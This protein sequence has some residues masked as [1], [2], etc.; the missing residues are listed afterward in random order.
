[1]AHKYSH[2]LNQN[3]E[4]NNNTTTDDVDFDDVDAIFE[5]LKKFKKV[6]GRTSF[7]MTKPDRTSKL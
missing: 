5:N 2:L 4:N 7:I 3:T 6:M 1:M